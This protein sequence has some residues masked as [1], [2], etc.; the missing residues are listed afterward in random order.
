MVT[1][2]QHV[3]EVDDVPLSG[4]TGMVRTSQL[5]SFSCSACRDFI[6]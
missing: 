2:H 4:K 1:A 5:S 3:G 6:L